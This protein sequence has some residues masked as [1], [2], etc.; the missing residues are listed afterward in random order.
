MI[1]PR[2]Y[3]VVEWTDYMTDILRSY[4]PIPQLDDPARWKE[5]ATGVALNPQVSKWFPPDPT[6]YTNWENWADDFNRVLP[7]QVQ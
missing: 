5:W 6:S 4:G 3:T 7:P 1:D 2:G